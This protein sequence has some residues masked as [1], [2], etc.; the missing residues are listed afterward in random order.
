LTWWRVG[1]DNVAVVSRPGAKLVAYLAVLGVLGLAWLPSEHVHS[2]T[3]DGR[4]SGYIHR[5]FASHH[6]LGAGAQ[7]GHPAD[8]DD[9]QYLRSAFTTA[10]S[11]PRLGPGNQFIV[12]TS[13]IPEEQPVPRHRLPSTFVSVHDPP[14]TDSLALRAP[15]SFAV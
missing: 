8:G 15:P 1:T 10:K 9:A 2:R 14:W 11:A 7:V 12:L 6:S 5:H 13:S 3:E 4:H